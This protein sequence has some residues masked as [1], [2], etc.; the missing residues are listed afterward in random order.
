MADDRTAGA[1]KNIGGKVQEGFG[2]LTGNRSQEAKGK[3]NQLEGTVQDMY[4]QAKDAASDFAG[5][6]DDLMRTIVE[7]QPYTVAV[8]ALALGFILGRMGRN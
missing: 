4:G 5:H 1:A 6:A 3:A 7:K 2:S 8:V